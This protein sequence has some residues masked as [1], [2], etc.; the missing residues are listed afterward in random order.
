MPRYIGGVLVPELPIKEDVKVRDEKVRQ[1]ELE[2]I[3]KSCS[4]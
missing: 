1:I 2:A 4:G 3:E